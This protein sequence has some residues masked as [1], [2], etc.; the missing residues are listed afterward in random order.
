[1][2]AVYGKRSWQACRSLARPL[3]VL[4]CERRAFI[5]AAMFGAIT[6]NLLNTFLPGLLIFLTGYTIGW[7]GTRHDPHMM[8]VVRASASAK[9]RYD[10]AKRPAAE[11]EIEI[12]SSNPRTS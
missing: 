7:L 2:S 5:L 12:I 9:P 8:Q 10:P 1:M 4:G 11:V 6:F 3:T